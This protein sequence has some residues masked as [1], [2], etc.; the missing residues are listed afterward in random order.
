MAYRARL[1][2]P[3]SLSDGT[4]QARAMSAAVDAA[5]RDA[6]LGY[7]AKYD[8]VAA[9]G[10]RNLLHKDDAYLSA[11][12]FDTAATTPDG[13]TIDVDTV[14]TTANRETYLRVTTLSKLMP[15]LEHLR[16][17]WDGVADVVDGDELATRLPSLE[18]DAA[19]VAQA[20]EAWCG[21]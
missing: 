6:L 16:L 20:R 9:T 7:L 5:D 14:V 4:L 18:A 10:L 17:F 12:T 2:L 11:L 21:K 1:P 13:V 8:A 15:Y 3:V 19:T